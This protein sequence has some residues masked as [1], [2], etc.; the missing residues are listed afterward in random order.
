MIERRS[1][2]IGVC[3]L[4][5]VGVVRA[6]SLYL[7]G[8]PSGIDGGNWLAFGSLERPGLAYP[9]LIPLA[10][11]V[12]VRLVGPA[13]ATAIAG[14]SVT[15]APGLAVLAVV[16][17]ARHPAAGALAALVITGS[18]AIGEVAAWGGYPQP[19]AMAFGVLA[20]AAASSWLSNGRIRALCLF[21]GCFA[22]V[23]ASSHLVAIPC[24]FAVALLALIWCLLRPSTMRR[25]PAV[26][27]GGV[28][29]FVALLPTYVALFATLAQ[30]GT[31]QPGDAER[32]LGIAWPLCFAVLIA[33]PVVLVLG[34]RS[35]LPMIEA[36]SRA[37]V[38]LVASSAAGI[39]WVAA[40]VVTREPRL[41]YDIGVLAVLTASVIVVVVAP[42]VRSMAVR[43]LFSTAL[44]AA[45]LGLVATGLARFPDQ[46][47]FYRVLTPDR[48]GAIEWLAAHPAAG[49]EVIVAADVGGVPIGWWT[50]GLVGQEVRYAS[51]LRWLRFPSERE[52]AT[53][54]NL[55]LYQSG[56]PSRASASIAAQ[57]G[58]A[59][60]FLPSA[61]AFGVAASSPPEGWVIAFAS[62][63]TVVLAPSPALSDRSDARW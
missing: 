36:G 49:P 18:S 1:V 47:R 7:P 35:S 39:T 24:L 38:L 27:I 44:F 3:A 34:R 12:L 29:P 21:V 31:G 17:W 11:T 42:A 14:A 48:F 26:L 2:L 53:S 9:P 4:V 6:V 52:R 56:F 16:G 22:V 43:R 15:V 8:S 40:Y 57:E 28:G 25:A 13:I 60:V 33:A 30:P 55:F 37:E 23:V 59:Y 51:D 10:F 46:V 20:L 61:G 45:T 19:A 58:V 5:L 50:E 63:D 32:V 62:G 41:L 54:A